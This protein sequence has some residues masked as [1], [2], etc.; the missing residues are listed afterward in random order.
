MLDVVSRESAELAAASIEPNEPAVLASL[1]HFHEVAVL[2]AHLVVVAWGV[3]VQ[4]P[5][6]R[7]V[8]VAAD[9]VVT[10]TGSLRHGVNVP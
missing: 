3:V 8:D 6:K 5:V 1:H 2:Q 4:R 7:I 9:A 10:V